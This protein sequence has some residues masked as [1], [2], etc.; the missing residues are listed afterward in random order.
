MLADPL[1]RPRGMSHWSHRTSGACGCGT[2]C[3]RRLRAQEIAPLYRPLA[4]WDTWFM[5]R[6]TAWRAAMLLRW[7]GEELGSGCRVCIHVGA[8]SSLLLLSLVS[9]RGG[10]GVG[11]DRVGT[12]RTHGVILPSAHGQPAGE[13]A[14]GR[15]GRAPAGDLRCASSL[16]LSFPAHGTLRTC[17]VPSGKGRALATISARWLM[18][19]GCLVIGQ[20]AT[21][22]AD[23][24]TVNGLS[25]WRPTL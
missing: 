25:Y 15:A 2:C 22:R 9:W 13:I 3:P 19:D 12:R 1:G 6:V 18:G 24:K 4:I 10:Q 8:R 14:P 21:L 23:S 7:S 5:S 11:C 17:G 20:E 16:S